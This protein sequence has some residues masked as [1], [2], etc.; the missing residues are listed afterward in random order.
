MLSLPRVKTLTKM[1]GPLCIGRK[2]D[3]KGIVLGS[4]SASCYLVI[5]GNKTPGSNSPGHNPHKTTTSLTYT[6]VFV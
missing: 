4:R 2:L 3:F 6:S 1:L 5:T